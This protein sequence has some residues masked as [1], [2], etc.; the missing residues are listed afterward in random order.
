[1]SV[2]HEPQATSRV[3]VSLGVC[4]ITYPISADPC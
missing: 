3:T 1:M 4:P 2:A